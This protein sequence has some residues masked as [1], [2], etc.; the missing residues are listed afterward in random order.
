VGGLL[1]PWKVEGTGFFAQWRARRVVAERERRRW[2]TGLRKPKALRA[3]SLISTDADENAIAALPESAWTLAVDVDG[4]VQDGVGARPLAHVAELTGL[5]TRLEHWPAGV[6]LIVR[7]SKPSRRHERKLTTF[8][9]KTGWRYQ[10]LATT[11]DKLDQVPGSHHPHFL[12]V[13]YRSRG[14]AAEQ[15]VRTGK[16]LG[17]RNLPSKTWNVNQG[18][19]IAA[20]IANDLHAYTRLLGLDEHPD[21]ARATPDTLRFR[22]WHLPAR[23]AAHAHRRILKIATDWP[24]ASAFTDCWRRLAPL[25][26][27]G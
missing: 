23:L 1:R 4:E 5:A 15:A 8:E 7:R 20:N 16:A 24:W 9:K 27:P 22:L 17:L 21:L 10:I 19:I 12:D 18:W 6:R 14:G 3:S 26:D 13:L 11:I 2:L 25:P